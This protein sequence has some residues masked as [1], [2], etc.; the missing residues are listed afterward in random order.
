MLHHRIPYVRAYHVYI[1]IYSCIMLGFHKARIILIATTTTTITA[2]SSL[3]SLVSTYFNLGAVVLDAMVRWWWWL[4]VVETCQS[5]CV[6]NHRVVTLSAIQCNALSQQSLSVWNESNCNTVTPTYYGRLNSSTLL[7]C[8]FHFRVR[9]TL[10][11]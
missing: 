8:G 1:Y 6:E 4:F 2:T 11:P 3:T 9:Y 10:H 7:L 5:F